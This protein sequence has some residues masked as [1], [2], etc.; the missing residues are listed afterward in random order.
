MFYVIKN[1]LIEVE[2]SNIGAEILSI[3]LNGVNY[4]KDGNP[5]YWAGRSP[6]MFPICGRLYSGGYTFNGTRYEMP[7]H[8]IVKTA[9]FTVT[10]QAKNS[11]TFELK[12]SEESKITYP[13]DFTFAVTYTVK[14]N[15][16]IT[17]FSVKNDGEITMPFS[18]GA[19]PGFTVP[20]AGVGEFEDCYIEFSTPCPAKKVNLS[21]T[22][23][24]TGNDT[25]YTG[26]NLKIIP[27]K[28]E[29][30]N[31]DAIF[32]YDTAK[33]V[34]LKSSKSPHSIKV[35]FEGFKY[36]GFWQSANTDAD[37]VCIEPWTG[38]P[39]TDG[40]V[41][42]FSTKKDMAT[43]ESGKTFTLSYVITVE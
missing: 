35:D 38:I 20:I 40:I 19:H 11:I 10:N 5:K 7:L 2:I 34:T 21:K 41:D 33:T 39:S 15:S 12:S 18:L 17:E 8:G 36:I 22:C 24:L 43:L 16:L 29:L 30:F 37:F 26:E 4:I 13:F 9:Q 1:D 3:K 25:L 6:I 23:F 31:N 42:D 14:N 27:L 32:L 28:H